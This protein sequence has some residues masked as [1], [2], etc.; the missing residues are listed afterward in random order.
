MSL[1]ELF[2]KQICR[3]N[4]YDHWWWL[5]LMMVLVYNLI[6]LVNTL[7]YGVSR[8]SFL[9][10]H[11][12]IVLLPTASTSSTIVSLLRRLDIQMFV[13]N[14]QWAFFNNFKV[15]VV[16]QITWCVDLHSRDLIGSVMSFVRRNNMGMFWWLLVTR[17]IVI[18][19]SR[20]HCSNWSF[21][22]LDRGFS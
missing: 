7:M 18:S 13:P 19:L 14:H 12:L 3:L 1:V 8:L 17:I 16:C 6:P 9:I 11:G 5:L 4:V 10:E 2:F 22:S 15:H 21:R 20:A